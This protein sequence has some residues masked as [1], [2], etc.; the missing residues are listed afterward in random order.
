MRMS[1]R[2]YRSWTFYIV[3]AIGAM[4]LA[5]GLWLLVR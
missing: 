4:Y 3:S 1:D 5:S 2:Q